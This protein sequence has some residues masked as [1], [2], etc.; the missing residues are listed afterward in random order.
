MIKN[1]CCELNRL[2]VKS[3]CVRQ[4]REKLK[5]CSGGSITKHNPMYPVDKIA[6]ILYLRSKLIS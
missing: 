4:V 6:A 2:G 5:Y 3:F 1:T